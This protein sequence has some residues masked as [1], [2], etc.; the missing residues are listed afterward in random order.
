MKS[1]GNHS[2]PTGNRAKLLFSLYGKNS[3]KS[4]SSAWGVQS[5][6]KYKSHHH[7]DGGRDWSVYSMNTT[8]KTQILPLNVWCHAKCTQTLILLSS[9]VNWYT[10][11][12]KTACSFS[13]KCGNTLINNTTPVARG[14][15]SVPTK[16]NTSSSLT[17]VGTC[18]VRNGTMNKQL[19]P[20]LREAVAALLYLAL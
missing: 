1:E 12:Y 8:V 15:V 18:Q 10:V 9:S 16:A 3:P 4:H 14:A 6:S 5:T 20:E 11:Y 17:S 2:P 7:G 13:K 19:T